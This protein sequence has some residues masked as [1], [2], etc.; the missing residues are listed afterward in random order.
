MDK[1]SFKAFLA[2][3]IKNIELKSKT[4]TY[5]DHH[6]AEKCTVTWYWDNV[7]CDWVFKDAAI[8]SK[9][10]QKVRP[11]I[12]EVITENESFIKFFI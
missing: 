10:T 1:E 4:E 7:R 8:R 5:W 6:K 9:I 2:D 12:D 3:I 11:M